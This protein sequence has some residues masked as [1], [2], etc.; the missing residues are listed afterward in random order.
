MKKMAACLF[1]LYSFTLSLAAFE[2]TYSVEGW[3]PYE[4]EKY[5]GTAVI[6]K[7]E[8]DVY[9]A[10]WTLDNTVYRGTGIQL[11]DQISFAFTGNELDTD[12]TGVQVYQKQEDNT[13]TG[14][15]VLMG[16]TLVGKE[17]I[18]LNP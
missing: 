12:A 11:G 16:E 5:T 18:T 1:T 7:K 13:Y 3:D 14:T 8:A 17:K 10:K 9:D 6:T 4:K 2:G 15:W